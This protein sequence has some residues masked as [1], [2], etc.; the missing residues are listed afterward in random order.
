MDMKRPPGSSTFERSA[1]SKVAGSEYMW[2]RAAQKRISD[3]DSLAVEPSGAFT[4]SCTSMPQR[5][6]CWTTFGVCSSTSLRDV[7]GSPVSSAYSE[8]TI[9]KSSPC[10]VGWRPVIVKSSR[11]RK[12]HMSYVCSARHVFI[13]PC[14]AGRARSGTPRR[15]APP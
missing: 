12:R 5:P 9:A 7:K 15:R 2:G 14:R 10:A 6:K 11:E 8:S 4:P 13:A 3:L 1:P